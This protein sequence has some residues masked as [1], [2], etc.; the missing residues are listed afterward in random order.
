MPADHS[1]FFIV[2]HHWH[3]SAEGIELRFWLKGEQSSQQSAQLWRVPKQESVCFV[4]VAQLSAWQ[5]LW[6]SRRFQVRIG[7]G[8]F[9]TLLG[10]VAL[11]VYSTA[12]SQQR[13]WVKE[14]RKQG[15]QVWE[16]DIMPAERYLMER[17]LFGSL[18]F[19]AG[20]PRPI[21]SKPAL[22]RL[23]IDIE[24]QWYQPGILPDLYSVA[25]ATDH[26]QLVLVID[27]QQAR[28]T[29]DQQA[30]MVQLVA[31]VKECLEQTVAFIQRTDPDCIIGWNVIDFDLQILQQHCDRHKVEFA[32]GRQHSLPNWRKRAD[33]TERYAIELEG[34]Q[35][36]DGPGAFRSAAWFFDDFSLENVAQSVLKRGKKIEHADDRV[37][38]IERLY[39]EDLAAFAHYN[40]EDAQLVLDLFEQAGL[41][42]F[43]VERSH[44]TGLPMARAGG[45]SA[46]F[47]TVYLPRL[48][49]QG[50]IANH[51]GEQT[52]QT[53]SPG[54]FVMESQPGIYNN[55]LVLDFKSLY[56]S[57]IRTFL[58]DPLGL[59][60]GLKAPEADSVEGF[61]GARFHRQ[62]HILPALIDGLWQ[63]RDEAKAQQNAPLSQ[64]IKIIMNSFYGVLGS[65]LCRFFDPRL[66]SSI[67]MRGH[68]ILQQTREFIEQE[69]YAVIYGDTDSVFV[70]AAEHPD[71]MQ[72]GKELAVKLNHWWQ[73]R[74][75]NEHGLT[76]YLEIEFETH[77]QQ[78][79][80]PTIRGSE[81]GSK[82][83]YAGWLKKDDDFTVVFK[84][85]EAVR[86]D[87]TPLAK[88]FQQQLYRLYFQGQ[89][90]RPLIAQ[91]VAQLKAGELDD[92][93][94]Y[95]KTLRRRPEQYE[96][97]RPPHVQA[98]LLRQ[99]MQPGWQGRK[100][101][102]IATVEGWQPI[103]FVS[104][105]PDYHHYIEK[106]LGPIA[107]A[108][109]QF[110]GQDFDA[111][112]DEQLSLF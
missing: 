33:Q 112:I 102:Y 78:F 99:R 81:K 110:L 64:A 93:I 62:Q 87:W 39:R 41:W 85:L 90:L 10:D 72:L 37:A 30:G 17:F 27:A 89:D 15:L 67:T 3:D 6:Q 14:G 79:V 53:A 5:Q 106:Q 103:P 75:L 2:S 68:Q 40:L 86:S 29:E 20:K 96:K 24:T 69:G 94:I 36:I 107:Q 111:L 48:H 92:Q 31:S 77:Y 35:V 63:A 21:R 16:D 44:L 104:A 100:I 19:E 83:R 59:N 95:K 97:N 52:L 49:R 70:H 34:R 12:V 56:P 73:Q 108:L 84:G 74:L 22:T 8:E 23:S 47:N 58:V 46:A 88:Q 43:L 11:P 42:Q 80:M 91:T 71:P 50:F 98:A 9:N 101:E 55:L 32:I 82:K 61:L 7:Q 38:E 57:I 51:V 1:P 76:S 66:A 60:L 28:L 13:R 54:G 18:V 4:A 45:S 109:L 26:E 65:H 105:K 25:L